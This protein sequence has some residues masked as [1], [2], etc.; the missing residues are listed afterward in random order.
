[1]ATVRNIGTGVT[2]FKTL[3]AHN[4]IRGRQPSKDAIRTRL[5]DLVFQVIAYEESRFRQF[6]DTGMPLFQS[7]QGFGV[8]QPDPPSS[9]LQIWNWM[10]NVD[11]GKKRYRDGQGTVRN[12]FQNTRNAHPTLPAL[13]TEM[14]HLADYQFYHSGPS[15]DAGYYWIPNSTFDDWVPG[16]LTAYADHAVSVEQAVSSGA[17][18]VDW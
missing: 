17:P 2:E 15:H 14:L 4:F 7:Q 6:D 16:T 3:H 10:A 1:M 9:G 18:P 13:T 11:E 5:G 12:H 8:M